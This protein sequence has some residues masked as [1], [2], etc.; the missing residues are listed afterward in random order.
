MSFAYRPYVL[1][2][3]QLD[4]DVSRRHGNI[5][6]PMEVSAPAD[7]TALWPALREFTTHCWKWRQRN[8]QMHEAWRKG[9]FQTVPEAAEADAWLCS[10]TCYLPLSGHSD[11][12]ALVAFDSL[13]ACGHLGSVS[14]K[15][16]EDLTVMLAPNM[17]EVR[18]EVIRRLPQS[19]K[20]FL[21]PYTASLQNVD[22]LFQAN[23]PKQLET[24][25]GNFVPNIPH[26]LIERP[27]LAFSRC[28]LEGALAMD[29]A[30]W[31]VDE[32]LPAM[33]LCMVRRLHEMA[34]ALTDDPDGSARRLY[35]EDDL[36]ACAITILH[37]Q[38]TN[39]I[40]VMVHGTN[41][42]VAITLLSAVREMRLDNLQD[43]EFPGKTLIQTWLKEGSQIPSGTP[44]D[45]KWDWKLGDSFRQ[46]AA[47]YPPQTKTN[48]GRPNPT[49]FRWTL[50]STALVTD[51]RHPKFGG[52]E[53]PQFHARGWVNLNAFLQITPGGNPSNQGSPIP[54]ATERPLDES[55]SLHLQGLYDC[56]QTL[57]C[58]KPASA[59]KQ[60]VLVSSAV[61]WIC[62]QQAKQSS[63]DTPEFVG[64]QCMI[65]VP[66]PQAFVNP[67][68]NTVGSVA[69]DWGAGGVLAHVREQLMAEVVELKEIVDRHSANPS[70]P[71]QEDWSKL[72]ANKDE[73]GI[74]QL[75]RA[76]FLEFIPLLYGL[77]APLR[78]DATCLFQQFICAVTNAH[79]FD[80]VLDLLDAFATLHHVLCQIFPRDLC[81]KKH[82]GLARPLHPEIANRI[83]QYVG[84]LHQALHHRIH[85]AYPEAPLRDIGL[86]R[87]DVYGFI[88]TAEAPLKCGVGLV[89]NEH[90]SWAMKQTYRRRD[91]LGIFT[92]VGVTNGIRAVH[93]NLGVEK[94]ARLAYF[95]TDV[96]HLMH[97]GSYVDYLHE[98]AHVALESLISHHEEIK[99]HLV[100]SGELS[101]DES[102]DTETAKDLRGNINALKQFAGMSEDAG[103]QRM[104]LSEIFV[105]SLTYK[106]LCP[107]EPKLFLRFFISRFSA[108]PENSGFPLVQT[109]HRFS[110]VF[111]VVFLGCYCLRID[112]K[113]GE[114]V[115]HD[116]P[117]DFEDSHFQKE[118]G[119]LDELLTW[120]GPYEHLTTEAERQSVK[121]YVRGYMKAFLSQIV[122][123]R[124][125]AD[126]QDQRQDGK[127]PCVN[128]VLKLA[129]YAFALYAD[130]IELDGQRSNLR[131]KDAMDKPESETCTSESK[132]DLDS[133]NKY[134][135][136]RQNQ[137]YCTGLRKKAS[138][139]E[140]VHTRIHQ[141]RV[142]YPYYC[143]NSLYDTLKSVDAML[144]CGMLL[145]SYL[146]DLSD[147]SDLQKGRVAPQNVPNKHPARVN[148][149]DFH[150]P[151]GHGIDPSVRHHDFV[152][153]HGQGSRTYLDPK[154]RQKRLLRQI[155]VMRSFWNLSAVFK[156]RR[157]C[158]L[159][160]FAHPDGPPSE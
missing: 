18:E 150:Q 26:K 51:G 98:A 143:S 100:K 3:V 34:Q 155:A 144:L 45:S 55:F 21:L 106:L 126:D 115:T 8:Q 139:L 107:G 73:G 75:L 111:C 124:F 40:C 65:S 123:N 56:V 137:F 74:Y 103:S 32:A 97:V 71:L 63:P 91:L 48:A 11:G 41:L 14:A 17:D 101:S 66:V 79:L 142:L 76:H 70:G 122:N 92:H 140:G 35:I 156:G 138:H 53:R 146:D 102:K 37:G 16:V 159:L 110:E 5:P 43:G 130:K 116:V 151:L 118:L 105:H 128:A 94:K 20:E 2:A 29:L 108:S 147:E 81:Q 119:C 135:K 153:Y 112:K 12:F 136:I 80:L 85:R 50:T 78:Q 13:D 132:S 60:L 134:R 154:K 57:E 46:L 148:V 30:G 27:L 22:W 88:Q 114:W 10:P 47:H 68:D 133:A 84:T 87:G 93:Q 1:V 120:Y 117:S 145:R 72:L 149:F 90:S 158:D 7:A 19:E 113:N 31:V 99:G 125:G 83:A 33:S 82:L 58:D 42:T 28:K 69:Q 52:A 64:L 23:E 59:P 49:L 129:L 96:T 54:C 44:G 160:R 39:E 15:T 86:L 9:R 104:R 152:L 25:P 77:P 109:I 67:K 6:R 127:G 61:E 141:G 95:A 157:F 36:N 24:S 89:A 121:D 62:K 131:A 38:G 4:S